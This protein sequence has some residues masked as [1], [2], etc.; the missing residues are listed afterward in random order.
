MTRGRRALKECAEWA[1]VAGTLA[2]LWLL[3]HGTGATVAMVR[4]ESMEPAIYPGD[5]V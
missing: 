1:L 3:V 2:G 4:T 5:I